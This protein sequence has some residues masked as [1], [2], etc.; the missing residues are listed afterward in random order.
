M[1]IFD[2]KTGRFKDKETGNFR[3]DIS[4]LLSSS[5]R[6]TFKEW[7]NE[8]TLEMYR[9]SLG[10]KYHTEPIEKPRQKTVIIKGKV[11]RG[12]RRSKKFEPTTIRNYQDYIDDWLDDFEFVLEEEDT[13]LETP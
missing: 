3:S 10:K 7:G 8:K 4:G 2:P 5:G 12:K 11:A 9:K 1:I 6:R 13:D